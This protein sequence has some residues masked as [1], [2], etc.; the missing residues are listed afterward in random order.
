[1][2]KYRKYIYNQNEEQIQ[3]LDWRDVK[4][5]CNNTNSAGGLDVWTKKELH[6]ISDEGFKWITQWLQLIEDT[7]EW[8]KELRQARAV[9]LCKDDNKAQDPMSY[10]II[11]INSTFFRVYGSVR[12]KNFQQWT[13]KWATTNMFAGVPGVGAEEGWYITQIAFEILRLQGK[14]ITAGSIDVY[15]CVDQINRKLVYKLAKQAG[16]PKQVLE[17]YFQ[18]I[19]NLDVRFQIGKTL[20]EA[21][22][23]VAS[24]P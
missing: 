4:F 9:F 13:E 12:M 19:D 1:M 18:Y 21:H 22:R 10:R 24:I 2:V 17:T 11:K 15:R 8:P 7:D 20:G 6:M 16:M 5:A 23:D 14:E 3:P